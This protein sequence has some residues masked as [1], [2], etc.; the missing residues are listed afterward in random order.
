MRE[1]ARMAVECRKDN[2]GEEVKKKYEMEIIK[3]IQERERKKE[4]ERDRE[5]S[6]EGKRFNM[7]MG[8]VTRQV[9]EARERLR[10]LTDKNGEVAFW[11]S[12][13]RG[14]FLCPLCV[15]LGEFVSKT[16]S[17]GDRWGR[18]RDNRRDEKGD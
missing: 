10:N 17:P 18:K 8:S 2:G 9:S 7:F 6:A 14:L 11:V 4:M 15:P 13:F 1:I 3:Q 12:Q 5:G 16:L